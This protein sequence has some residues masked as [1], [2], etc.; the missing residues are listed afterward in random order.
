MKHE[1][2]FLFFGVLSAL[3][4]LAGVAVGAPVI[5]EYFAT[6][7]VPKLPSAVLSASLMI[8]AA[9]SLTAGVILATVARVGREAKRLAYLSVAPHVAEDE[10]V[11]EDSTSLLRFTR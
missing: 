1:K 6:G 11:V 7:L 4:V 2:P 3:A 9:L 10:R 8:I 5:V